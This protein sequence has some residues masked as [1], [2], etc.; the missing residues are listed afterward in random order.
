MGTANSKSFPTV[1][2]REFKAFPLGNIQEREFPLMPDVG[3][4][5]GH[6]GDKGGYV[7]DK[8][9]RSLINTIISRINTVILGT[10]TVILGTYTVILEKNMV[11]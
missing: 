5:Y 3:D 9:V 4:Q 2:E 1:W 7:V 8:I 10:Y 6:I 11:I